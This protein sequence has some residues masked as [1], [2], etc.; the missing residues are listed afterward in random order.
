MFFYAV[1]TYIIFPTIGYYL[2][3][4]TIN[5]AGNGFIVGSL[6]SIVLWLIVGKNLANK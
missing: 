5:A 3:G 2:G 1:L 6:I 4:R